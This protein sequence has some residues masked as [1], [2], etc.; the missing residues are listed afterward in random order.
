LRLNEKAL[1]R[2]S[3]LE[4]CNTGLPR[5]EST[6]DVI[7]TIRGKSDSEKE[8]NLWE[9]IVALGAQLSR[10]PFDPYREKIKLTTKIG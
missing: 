10:P 3:I 5:K 9:Y 6:D 2:K 7:R 8:R 4:L 1:I